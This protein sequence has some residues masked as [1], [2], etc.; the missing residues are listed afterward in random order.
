MIIST[1]IAETKQQALVNQQFIYMIN[2]WAATRKTNTLFT[3]NIQ[4]HVA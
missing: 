1:E 3:L 4:T 2:N